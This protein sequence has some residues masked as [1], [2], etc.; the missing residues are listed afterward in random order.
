MSESVVYSEVKY[1]KESNADIGR[2]EPQIKVSLES[3]EDDVV[4]AAVVH[5]TDYTTQPEPPKSAPADSS[6]KGSK[7]IRRRG[8]LLLAVVVL[9][10]LIL[11]TA[12]GLSLYYSSQ[13]TTTNAPNKQHSAQDN[14]HTT[15]S[16]KYSTSLKNNPSNPT[17]E[18]QPAKCGPGWESHDGQCYFF[19]NKTLNWTQSQEECVCM[20]SHLAIIND[21][22]EQK[23]LMG[24]IAPKMQEHEDKFWIGLND[25]QTEDTW[26]WVDNTSLNTNKTFW[27][28][29]QPDNWKG[30]NNEYP[31]GEDCVRMGEKNFKGNSAA[32]AGWVD[33]ACVREFKFICETKAC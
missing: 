33:A 28:D 1:K 25:R 21:E 6:S 15:Q 5:K 7:G 13:N 10:I 32:A 17:A 11:G 9:C 20:K 18:C 19:S 14:R 29:K 16:T 27:L 31:D 24:I 2:T 12:I 26:R 3:P 22:G 8:L 4:Y 23:L 30:Y